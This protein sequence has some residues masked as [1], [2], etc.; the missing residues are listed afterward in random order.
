MILM[1]SRLMK[2]DNEQ[3]IGQALKQFLRENGLEEKVLET[4]IYSRW[5]EM[6]GRSISLQTKRL[7]LRDGVLMVFLRSSVLRNELSMR[8]SEL[9]K[10]INARLLPRPGL[11]RLEFR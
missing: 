1:K 9:L 2:K 3:S 6:V 11:Q 8:Q 10:Q 4:E 5:E 7:Q